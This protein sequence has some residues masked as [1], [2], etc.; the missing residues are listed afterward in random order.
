MDQVN[1]DKF[2]KAMEKLGEQLTRMTNRSNELFEIEWE[3]LNQ[4]MQEALDSSPQLQVALLTKAL[5]FFDTVMNKMDEELRSSKA[6][7]KMVF[8]KL[9]E[10]NEKED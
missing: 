9:P 6:A 8:D 3:L 10:I 5:G 4:S 2:E 7:L 1:M